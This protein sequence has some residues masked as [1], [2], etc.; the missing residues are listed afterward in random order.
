MYPGYLQDRAELGYGEDVDKV[1]IF[2]CFCLKNIGSGIK[3]GG[4]LGI[5]VWVL[6]YIAL[7]HGNAAELTDQA[8]KSI[9]KANK[10]IGNRNLL[11]MSNIFFILGFTLSTVLGFIGIN[12]FTKSTLNPESTALVQYFTSPWK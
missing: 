8:S 5:S 9:D 6:Y 7:Q 4:F 10:T 12:S 3:F 1:S 11:C 2:L